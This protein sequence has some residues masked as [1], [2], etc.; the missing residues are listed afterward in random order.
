MRLW[1]L[2]DQPADIDHFVRQVRH[3]TAKIPRLYQRVVPGF[4]RFDPPTW[5]PDAEFDLSYHVRHIEMPGEGTRRALFDLTTDLYNEPLD[6][7]RPLWRFVVIDGVEGGQGALYAIFHHAISDGIGQ[8]RMA[9]L[10]Q[11]MQRDDPPAP[12]V[13]LE[14]I[15][16]A[17]VAAY[18]QR[19][20]GGPDS[21]AAAA[22]ASIGHVTRRNLGIAKRLV[23]K[24]AIVPR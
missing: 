24:A 11:S 5:V 12:E 14:A 21:M 8:L 3:G 16:A 7:T 4:G 1:T 13:D 18:E 22:R 17:E 19:H 6:R 2:L 15:I 10:Y 23:G 9:E 20:G